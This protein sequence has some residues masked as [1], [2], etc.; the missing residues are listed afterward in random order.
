MQAVRASVSTRGGAPLLPQITLSDIGELEVLIHICRFLKPKG[1]GRLACVSSSFGRKI[2]WSHPRRLFYQQR[3]VVEETARRWVAERPVKKQAVAAAQWSGWLRR[4]QETQE[5]AAIAARR[6][7]AR[8]AKAE[9]RRQRRVDRRKEGERLYPGD[10]Y[11]LQQAFWLER[12]R[13]GDFHD[14]YYKQICRSYA[15][16]VDKVSIF[17]KF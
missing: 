7:H 15:S 16:K 10:H 8:A 3:S 6:R 17:D 4:M 5:T 13:G 12:D 11:Q 9:A 14:F 1:L 2:T